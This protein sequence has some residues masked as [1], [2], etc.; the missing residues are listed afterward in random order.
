MGTIV[1]CELGLVGF[2]WL[3]RHVLR[4]PAEAYV[5]A[6]VLGLPI[7]MLFT[8]LFAIT[9]PIYAWQEEIFELARLDDEETPAFV[10]L[11]EDG[12][13]YTYY[14]AKK[15][16]MGP[17]LE[18]KRAAYNI[19]VFTEKRQ[20]A[21]LKVFREEFTTGWWWIIAIPRDSRKYEFHIPEGSLVRK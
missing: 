1:L 2:I 17:Q 8:A 20:G 19:I 21:A 18:E 10:Y 6:V 9:L 12:G 5:F 3:W 4:P 15:T 13:H 16:D 11:K 7:G 14:C